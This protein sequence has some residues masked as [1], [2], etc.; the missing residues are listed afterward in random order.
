M[1]NFIDTIKWFF[2]I[3]KE[4]FIYKKPNPVVINHNR[5]NLSI[6]TFNIRRDVL[7]DGINNWQYRKENI[8]KMI[9]EESPDIICMHYSISLKQKY[10]G[11]VNL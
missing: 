7:K 4:N 2:R 1:N 6:M 11:F 9:Q 3:T 5:N 10:K 8:V